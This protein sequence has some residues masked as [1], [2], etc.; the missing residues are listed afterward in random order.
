VTTGLA[1]DA[2][3]PAPPAERETFPVRFR[4]RPVPAAW[5]ATIASR[6]DVPG[7]LARPPFVLGTAGSQKQR[8]I[9]LRLLLGWL[10]DQPGR[11]WQ[12]RWLASGADAAGTRWRQIPAG[13]LRSHGRYSAGRQ[14]TLCGALHVAICADLVRPSPSWFA[15]AVMRGG[16]LAAR[17]SKAR[18]PA[19]FARL[20][21]MCAS[22][23]VS[24]DARAHIMHRA[25]VIMGAK[26]GVLGGITAGDAAWGRTLRV[27]AR[28]HRL[29]EIMI[30]HGFRWLGPRLEGACHV[31]SVYSSDAACRR[32]V[33]HFGRP[34]KH[35]S[36]L[37]STVLPVSAAGGSAPLKP[38]VQQPVGPGPGNPGRTWFGACGDGPAGGRS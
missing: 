31:R 16:A 32:G 14:D 35:C 27:M 20:G 22:D 19:G 9:G 7:R 8:A 38:G 18:D 10:A 2:A 25:A 21:E 26:G 4:P 36:S 24:A 37:L 33:R 1:A 28:S 23:R 29:I 17:M 11:S 15:A 5:P 3:V 12:Q 30:R 34:V 13:W 6:E